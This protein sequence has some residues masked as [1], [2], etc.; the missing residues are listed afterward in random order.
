MQ[1]VS[2]PLQREYDLLYKEMD[3]LYREIALRAGISN[4]AFSVLYALCDLGNGCLQKDICGRCYLSKQTVHS[5]VRK[6]ESE[7]YL[8]MEPGRGRD[9][10]LFLTQEGEA[11]ANRAVLPASQAENRTLDAMSPSDRETLIRLTAQYVSLFKAETRD[12]RP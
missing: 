12:L 3:D 11:L 9:V 10:H 4:A 1:F 8:R 2:H 5:A 7:G 6:L